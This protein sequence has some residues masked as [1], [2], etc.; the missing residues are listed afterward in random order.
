MASSSSHLDPALGRES[1]NVGRVESHV[2]ADL[3]KGDAS[4]AHE[5][6]HEACRDAQP[7]GGLVNIDERSAGRRRPRVNDPGH[8]LATFDTWAVSD[9]SE[10]MMGRPTM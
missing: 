1:I 2:P 8:D 6:S 9:P 10:S 3:V 7:C 4:F 5:A